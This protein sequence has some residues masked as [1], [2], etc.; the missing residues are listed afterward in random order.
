MGLVIRTV[1]ACDTAKTMPQFSAI[2]IACF[3]LV[4]PCCAVWRDVERLV[5]RIMHMRSSVM[6]TFIVSRVSLS[7]SGILLRFD[8]FAGF[9]SPVG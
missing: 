7:H 2:A 5:L 8:P 6:R 1:S 3:L 9:K 4:A